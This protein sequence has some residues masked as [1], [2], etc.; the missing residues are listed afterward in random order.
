MTSIRAVW[1]L[2]DSGVV[3]LSRRYAT[4]ERRVR[5][6]HRLS[7][8]SNPAT[9]TTSPPPYLRYE[10]ITIPNDEQF[11]EL[12]R[13]EFLN[14]FTHGS[15]PN[16]PVVSLGDGGRHDNNDN[17]N[18][19][20]NDNNNMVGVE[21]EKEEEEDENQSQS[22]R[23]HNIWPVITLYRHGAFLV[24]VPE[25]D[26]FLVA[27]LPQDRPPAVQ[28]PSITGT[29]AL[30][31]DLAPFVQRVRDKNFSTSALA[32]LQCHLCSIMPF[33]TP[34]E[35]NMDI[36]DAARK[37]RS[38]RSTY[39]QKRPA[40]KPD[41]LS[42]MR[43]S[44]DLNVKETVSA[45]I[46]GRQPQKS[47][48]EPQRDGEADSG[49]NQNQTQTQTQQKGLFDRM[50]DSSMVIP[51]VCHIHGTVECM[52]NLNGVPE[53]SLTISNNNDGY[54][55]SSG[56]G[57]VRMGDRTA[58]QESH[59]PHIVLV[60][61]CVLPPSTIA[62]RQII[63]SPPIG[64][65]DLV[66]Y[67]YRHDQDRNLN[68]AK[69]E[70]NVDGY[71]P[72]H[73]HSRHAPIVNI[74]VRALYQVEPIVP[75][76]RGGQQYDIRLH[77][78]WGMDVSSSGVS[79]KEFEVVLPFGS[80][81]LHHTLTTTTGTLKTIDV[82]TGDDSNVHYGSTQSKL[83]WVPGSKF[84]NDGA[85]AILTGTITMASEV[86]P[87][88]QLP[89]PLMAAPALVSGMCTGDRSPMPLS[90]QT[91][92]LSR[93]M[94]RRTVEKSMREGT[95]GSISSTD[96]GDHGDHGDR[97]DRGDRGKSTSVNNRGGTGDNGV[98]PMLQERRLMEDWKTWS[99]F[100]DEDADVDET[101]DLMLSGVNCYAALNFRIVGYTMS[102]TCVNRHGIA[103]QPSTSASISTNVELVSDRYFVWN[104]FGESRH[105]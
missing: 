31:E 10:Q 68:Q 23:H 6:R 71:E 57:R 64:R 56:S 38:A 97:G 91:E 7:V 63:F 20:H 79:V 11:S 34:I 42:N 35:T 19:N 61:E 51:D 95:H 54:S 104:K 94:A 102:G 28:L 59:F 37:Q 70:A 100:A 39:P 48:S 4:V 45:M 16:Y 36:V 27:T 2:D 26:G 67:S 101:G 18:N 46:Y 43:Q 69:Q 49:E 62:S 55:N 60:H 44:L 73:G 81:I 74:P 32:S 89:E 65:F 50:F 41:V 52:S 105:V 5:R 77:L 33:G 3:L 98:D 80:H 90:N 12:F 47:H 14:Y 76:R 53:V 1:L 83:L 82:V 21:N 92:A 88:P 9:N 84:K 40:W 30:L 87:S 86:R 75:R 25:V 96:H 15:S 8:N 22:R 58:E 85:D 99:E 17:H 66:R 93:H 72:E 29:C 103:V 13:T 24:A 78:R